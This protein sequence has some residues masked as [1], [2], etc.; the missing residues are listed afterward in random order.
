M[1]VKTGNIAFRLLQETD[2][3]L[4]HRWLNTPHVSEWWSL[5][6][7]HHPSLEEVERKYPPRIRGDEPVDCFLIVYDD[8][9]IG[10]IQSCKLDDYPAEK[11]MFGLDTGYA[12]IDL[13]IGEEAYVHKGLGS[14]II[15][16][17]VK[18]IVFVNYDVSCCIIDPEPKNVIAI[19]AYS[20]AGF[21]HFK[22]VRNSKDNIDAYL[23]SVNREELK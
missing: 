9:P 6:G 16:K 11:A 2:L 17:F 23:M 3:P 21:K 13:F 10:M 8:K 18:E 12:G 15:R 19:K 4:M 14:R 1:K 5:D 7:N 20:K 22:T